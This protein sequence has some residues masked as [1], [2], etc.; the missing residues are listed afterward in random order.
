M[1]ALPPQQNMELVRGSHDWPPGASE[2]GIV[3]RPRPNRSGHH[4]RVGF[5]VVA[6]PS[7]EAGEDQ[8]P[9][10]ITDLGIAVAAHLG[11]R[12]EGTD[13]MPVAALGDATSSPGRGPR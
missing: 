12:I 10:A 6:G 1:Q 5:W 3:R 11:V 8:P 2:L 9:I 4:T 7:I 13:A